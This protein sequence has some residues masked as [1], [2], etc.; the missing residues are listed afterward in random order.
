[1]DASLAI[2]AVVEGTVSDVKEYG[3]LVNLAAHAELVGFAALHQARD[4]LKPGEKVSAVVLDVSKAEGIVDLSLRPQLLPEK[5]SKSTKKRVRNL[6]WRLSFR[7]ESARLGRECT[8]APAGGTVMMKPF[9]PSN[10]DIS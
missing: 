8:L 9:V 2:G 10:S 7:F 4:G 1:L 6:P 3:V 5:S